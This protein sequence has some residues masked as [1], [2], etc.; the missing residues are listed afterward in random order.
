[1][2]VIPGVRSH[3]VSRKDPASLPELVSDVKLIVLPVL[4]FAS[5]VGGWSE[6]EG[7]QRQSIAL[8]QDLEMS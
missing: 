5:F 8:A 3:G 7:H 6:A 2:Y 1:M 4:F